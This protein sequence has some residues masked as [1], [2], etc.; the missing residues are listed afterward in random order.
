M[1]QR[2]LTEERERKE[3]RE[4]KEIINIFGLAL[5]DLRLDGSPPQSSH[6]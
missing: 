3:R 5:E 2:S 4:E 6:G 1:K